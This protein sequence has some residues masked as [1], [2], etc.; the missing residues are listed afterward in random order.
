MTTSNWTHEAA[1]AANGITLE[2][3]LQLGLVDEVLKAIDTKSTALDSLFGELLTMSDMHFGTEEVLM[4]QHSYPKYHLHVEE[5]ARLLDLIKGLKVRAA[6]GAPV[7]EEVGA[8]RRQISAH[9]D[10][11]DGEFETLVRTGA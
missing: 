2:H 7:K 1:V 10:G 4:R 9:I 5:H 8:L 3:G 11:L 6:T